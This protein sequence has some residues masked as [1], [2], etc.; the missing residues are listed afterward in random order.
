MKRVTGDTGDT[1]DTP[2]SLHDR[3]VFQHPKGPR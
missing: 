1:G 3:S 2:M